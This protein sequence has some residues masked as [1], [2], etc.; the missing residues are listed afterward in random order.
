M[1]SVV[2]GAFA[3]SA[4]MPVHLMRAASAQPTSYFAQNAA[5]S[6][7]T[8]NLLRNPI[9]QPVQAIKVAPA[10]TPTV[11]SPS[12]LAAPTVPYP[13]VGTLTQLITEGGLFVAEAWV[14]TYAARAVV[15]TFYN[16]VVPKSAQVKI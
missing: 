13:T 3:P 1:I 9:S 14:V 4:H 10:V 11:A 5:A 6:P 12:L 7:A 16:A 15:L 8:K 2:R